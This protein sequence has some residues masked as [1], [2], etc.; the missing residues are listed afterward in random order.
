MG[1]FSNNGPRSTKKTWIVIVA[2]LFIIIIRFFD[3]VSVKIL[4]AYFFLTKPA[5]IV[6]ELS[7]NVGNTQDNLK[8]MSELRTN[9]ITLLHKLNTLKYL[10]FENKKLLTLLG[11]RRVKG[12][13]FIGAKVTVNIDYEKKDNFI[14]IDKGKNYNIKEGSAVINADGLIGRI[15]QVGNEWSRVMLVQNIKS[16]LP[17]LMVKADVEALISGDSKNAVV[18]I[19][20][21]NK[22]LIEGDEVITSGTGELLPKGIV[23]G[24]YTK[25]KII[26]HVHYDN[27]DYVLIVQENKDADAYDVFAKDS[28][29]KKLASKYLPSLFGADGKIKNEVDLNTTATKKSSTENTQSSSINNSNIIKNEPSPTEKKIELSAQKETENTEKNTNNSENPSDKVQNL[30]ASEKKVYTI[31]GNQIL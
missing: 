30:K 18:E 7:K 15:I 12:Y 19:M 22:K 3:D 14:F 11:I 5:Q 9:N 4:D 21:E 29:L 6:S 1:R 13:E 16:K 28:T 20:S 17:I 8:I 23:V 25:G 10:E 2:I 26:S 27:L 24:T 31:Q